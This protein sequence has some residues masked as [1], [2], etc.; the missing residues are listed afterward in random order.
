MHWFFKIIQQTLTHDEHPS[1]FSQ[2]NNWLALE[3]MPAHLQQLHELKLLC[4][5]SIIKV[6]EP[7]RIMCLT[8]IVF[9]EEDYMSVNCTWRVLV[10]VTLEL[11]QL[12]K[13][14]VSSLYHNSRL[15]LTSSTTKTWTYISFAS[16]HVFRLWPFCKKTCDLT[17]D[18][19]EQNR[20]IHSCNARFFSP[21][22]AS[23]RKHHLPHQHLIEHSVG[24][25]SCL[26]KVKKLHCSHFELATHAFY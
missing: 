4:M 1:S 5:S 9:S 13:L 3:H 24:L 16:F 12:Y 19:Q 6:W 10:W 8:N 17:Q 7:N 2:Y 18:F 20:H 21:L 25:Q 14:C 11:Q 23:S 22:G 15:A 26:I